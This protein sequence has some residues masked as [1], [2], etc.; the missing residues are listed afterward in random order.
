MRV[1]HAPTNVANQPP[2]QAAALRALGHDAECWHYGP[3]KFGFGADRL[4]EPPQTPQEAIALVNDVL[5]ADYDVIHLHFAR[6]LVP[7]QNPLGELWDLPIWRAAGK[8]VI[9]SLHGT[10]MREAE[11]EKA[12]DPW[13]YYHFGAPFGD[14]RSVARRLAVIRRFADAM[15]VSAGSNFAHVPDANYLP[16]IVDS[17]RIELGAPPTREVPIIAH[18]PSR[19]STKGT[20]F[21]LAAF[22][23]LRDQGV[24]FEVDLIEGVDNKTAIE[25]MT[26]ADIVVEKLLGDGYGVTPLEALASGR[27]VL[28]RTTPR[29]LAPA[30]DYPG[31]SADPST[32]VAVLRDLIESPERRGEIGAKGRPFVLAN[33]SPAVVGAALE[34]LYNDE[35]VTRPNPFWDRWVEG[36]PQQL[37]QLQQENARLRALLKER[38][39]ATPAPGAG[40]KGTNL[41]SRIAR[42]T[43]KALGRGGA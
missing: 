32:A 14:P 4:L 38:A 33:H 5:A 12:I 15:T 37:F 42:R 36:A 43:R 28:G 39:S 23:A 19:R 22:D 29:A 24:A 35:G 31:L 17:D 1:L 30:P 21:V 3:D 16:L 26:A 2:L 34:R 10:D 41:G 7:T 18:A 40:A 11:R 20:D 6:S 9:M 27:V 25:R 13:S 8:R